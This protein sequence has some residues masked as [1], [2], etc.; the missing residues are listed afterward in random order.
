MSESAARLYWPGENPIGKR[1]RFATGTSAIGGT[2]WRTIVGLARDANL[3]DVRHASPMLYLPM[4]QFAWQGY[5]AIRTAV[6]LASIV[7]SLRAA[8]KETDAHSI[9]ST[10]QTMDQLLAVPLSQPR[11][12]ALLMSSFGLVALLLAA[13]GL[14]GVMSALVRDQTREI[15]IRVALGA[16]RT[17]VRDDVL[18]RAARMTIGGASVGL[19]IALALSRFLGAVLFEVSPT[20]PVSLVVAGGLLFAI[21][22]IAAYLPAR[23][24]MRVDPVEA[25]RAE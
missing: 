9:L 7:P 6:S 8:A 4:S 11:L 14:Y 13:I 2:D 25:L 17:I 3:R 18:R 10:A 21:G 5:A 19:I 23:R 20:D 12:G 24:A 15:G 22:A 16:T 1:L